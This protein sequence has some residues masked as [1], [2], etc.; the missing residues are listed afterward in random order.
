MAPV[1]GKVAFAEGFSPLATVA[2]RTCLAAL[3]LLVVMALFFRPF[4]EIYPMGLAGCLLAGALNGAGSLLY[5]LALGRLQANVGQ[6]VFL[7]YP[8]FVSLWLMLDHQPPS[9]LALLRVGLGTLAVFLLILAPGGHVD[10]F[11]AIMMLGAAL[12]YAL[13]LPINQRVL[14]DVP[15]PTVTLYTLLAMSAVV[16]PASALLDPAPLP[17]LARWTPIIL[18]AAL[19]F[20]SRLL[21]FLGVKRI[22]GLQTSLLG[23]SELLVTIALGHGLLGEHLTPMQWSSAG[24]VSLSLILVAREGTGSQRGARTGWLSWISARTASP[25][26]LGPPDQ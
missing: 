12:L 15:P 9:K 18:L 19:M 13:H 20:V 26:L 22:G 24:L 17:R 16:L 5:F 3:A 7:L 10:L 25:G 14:Y 21:L 11:G 23:L 8:C 1:F 4:L 6:L 2:L